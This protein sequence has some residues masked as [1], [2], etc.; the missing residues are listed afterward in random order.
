MTSQPKTKNQLPT[1]V[2][3]TREKTPYNFKASAT[4]AG[5]VSRKLEFGD[6]ALEGHE[7]LICIERKRSITEL[8]GNIGKN[9]ERFKRELERMRQCKLRFIV[10]E[11]YWSSILRLGKNKFVRGMHPNSVFESIISWKLKY[12]VNF[13]FAGTRAMAHRIT[14]SLLLKAYKN[15]D[16]IYARND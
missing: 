15:R 10:V 4:L 3:D 16:I 2:I 12:D 13:I 1:I 6:Y 11:D 7:N 14:R 8:C 5:V 9:R